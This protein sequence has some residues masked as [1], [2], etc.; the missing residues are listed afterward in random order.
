LN[1]KKKEMLF[2]LIVVVAIFFGVSAVDYLPERARGG[3]LYQ[4]FLQKYGKKVLGG[5]AEALIFNSK[6]DHFS[7]STDTFAQRYYVNDLYWDKTN[8][9]VYYEIGGEGTLNGPPGKRKVWII[10]LVFN[11]LYRWLH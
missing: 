2:S 4:Q 11:C 7:N 6:V 10:S 5:A 9:P 3:L 8:G 1:K